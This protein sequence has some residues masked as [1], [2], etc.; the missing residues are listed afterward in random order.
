MRKTFIAS[1]IVAALS[2]CG[3][4]GGDSISQPA[5]GAPST[6]TAP[7]VVTTDSTVVPVA[8]AGT[9]ADGDKL[10]A[11]N[12]LNAQRL[13]CGFGALAQSTPLDKAAQ[14]HAD[15]V[16]RNVDAGH[17]DAYGHLENASYSGFTGVSPL[18]RA[19]LQGYGGL[20]VA[21]D[22]SVKASAFL[23]MQEFLSVTYHT[24]SALGGDRDI[25]IGVSPTTTKWALPV[26][27]VDL[28]LRSTADVQYLDSKVMA[29][30]PCDGQTGIAGAQY[31][32]SPSPILGRD[33]ALNPAGRSIIAMVRIGQVLSVSEFTLSQAG[34]S[35]LKATLLTSDTDPNKLLSSNA[36]VLIPDAPL[37]AKTT[38][39]AKLVG[40]N[41]GQ[42]INKTWRFTTQ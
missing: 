22:A 39:T 10:A 27:V 23:A 41:N 4:G 13:Q 16:A 5:T 40:T 34:G 31:G 42:P 19:N 30:F 7:P 32:E 28:G 11:Y 33:F 29:M 35:P 1:S 21:E 9:Y 12:Y 6:P 14:G 20:G 38:Y 2:G 3:G 36:V 25:G 37:A 18:D 8:P 24:I 26:V 15:Y 17:L